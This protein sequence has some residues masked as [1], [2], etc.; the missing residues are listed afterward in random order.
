[1]EKREKLP[2]PQHVDE[3][4]IE[5]IIS[6]ERCKESGGGFSDNPVVLFLPLN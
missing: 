4:M 3:I 5:I 2:D 6:A 1:M